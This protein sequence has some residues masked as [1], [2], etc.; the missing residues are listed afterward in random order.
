MWAILW[1][2]NADHFEY[3]AQDAATKYVFL[4]LWVFRMSAK[5]AIDNQRIEF[6]Y[7]S[8]LRK[9][10]CRQLYSFVSTTMLTAHFALT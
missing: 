10:K 5:Q 3:L 2:S 9:I 1:F 7:V 4:I 6:V 8:P